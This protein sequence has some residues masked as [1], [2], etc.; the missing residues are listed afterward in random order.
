MNI[1]SGIILIWTGTHASIPTGYVRE[2]DLDSKFLKGAGNGDNPNVAGGN[3]THTH[4]SPTGAHTHT[5]TAHT[6]T[7]TLGAGGGGANSTG[8]T[9]QNGSIQAHTHSNPT[10]AST[11]GGALG[12]TTVSYGAVSN[13]PEFKEVIFIKSQGTKMIPD[14][15][16]VLSEAVAR[17]GFNECDGTNGTVDYRGKYLRGAGT[18]ANAGTT[19]GAYSNTHEIVHT[20]TV[21][22]HTHTVN[23]SGATASAS[24]QTQSGSELANKTH[25]HTPTLNAG[26]DVLNA[27]PTV[28]QDETVEPAYKKL[29]MIQ[30]IS[31]GAKPAIKGDIALYLGT[32]STI[33]SGWGIYT[34]M[35]DKFL[36]IA[37]GVGEVGDTGGS[38]THTH[39]SKAHTHTGAHAHTA[40]N[41]THTAS[42]GTSG[43]GTN[44]AGTTTTHTVTIASATTEYDTATTE[45][46][47]SD[48]QPEH[49]TVTFIKLLNTVSASAF[50]GLFVDNIK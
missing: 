25:T 14:D 20:H 27:N 44:G 28:L 9:A 40:S 35:E 50:F 24:V 26:T 34:E 49:K 19:G 33:P 43:G 17:T 30:N 41:V 10:V 22:T 11:T 29:M 7:I 1:P 45:A 21:A 5:L 8:A 46:G 38:N 13:N 37:S 31:G 23:A 18:G 16:C 12:S 15:V 47:S 42:Y 6:H 3:A 39:A 4:T 32:L 48:N 2:T 36:K